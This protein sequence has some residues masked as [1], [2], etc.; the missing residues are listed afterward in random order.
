MLVAVPLAAFVLPD[1]IAGR[2]IITGD[3]LQQN[4]PLHVLVGSML[5]HGELP[6]WNQYIFSG[7][8]LMA[9]FNAGAFYPLM[10]LFVILPDRAAWIATEVILFS[11][12]AIGMYV[13]LRA[14]KLS[15]VACLLGAATFA[16]AGPVLSQ[17]N[18]VDMTEGYVAIPWMLLAVLHIVRDGRWRWSILLGIGFATVILAGAPEAMLDEAILVIAFAAMSAGLDP[19]R[20]WRVLSRGAAGTALALSLA[21]IQ[22]LP[23]LEAI[24]NSQR[25]SGVFA[26]A[27]SFPTPFSI[28]AVVPYLDGGYG[29]LGEAQFF[30]QYN[31]PEVGIYLGILPLIALLTLLHPRWPSRL[32]V[33]DRLTWYVVGVFGFVLALGSNTPLERFFNAVPLYG[34]QRLQSRNMII[35]ATAMSVLFA[36]WIDR[37]DAPRVG[38]RWSRYDR[39]VALVPGALVLGLAV[40]AITATGSLVHVFAGVGASTAVTKT[41]RIAT[42]VALAFCAGA[43]ALVWLRPRLKKVQWLSLAGVFVAVDLGLMGLTS[44]LTMVPP[45]DLVSGTTPV[46]QL[47]AAHLVPGGRFIDYDPQTYNSYPESP[48]GIPD[49]NIIPGLPSVSG[50]A[51]IVNG[52]Y[53]ATTH[54]HEQGNVD[55]GQLGNGTLSRLNLQEIVTLPEYFLLPLASV[56]A[57]ATGAPPLQVS[58]NIGSDPV[59]PRGFS[60]TY[61]QTSYPYVPGPRPPLRNGQ[62]SSWFFGESLEP[63]SATLLFAHPAVAGAALRFGV[64]DAN[65]AIRWTP[66]V[67][68]AAGAQSV[69]EPLPARQGVALTVQ[70]LGTVPSQSAVIKVGTQAYALSGALSTAVVPGPWRLAGTSQGFAVFTSTRPP[71]PISATTTSGHPVRVHVISTTTKSEEVRIDTPGPATVVRSV[72]WDQGWSGSVSVNGAAGRNVPVDSFDLVQRVSIPAGN[73]VV[74]FRYRP[75]HL[76]AGSALSIGAV[77][78]LLVLLV[79]WLVV[80]RRR[81]VASVTTTEPERQE[82]PVTV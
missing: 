60:S 55:I 23:G 7:T 50:Y 18:H 15:T 44:Q 51:S 25:G 56:P 78:L 73:D 26:A 29:H 75:P 19:Q 40:W 33:R 14:L 63:A 67:P 58:D 37:T 71:V 5:S 2:L 49:L 65:G 80:R 39:L 61:N 24:R 64:L 34:H 11:A 6:F 70:A 46:Q 31:L 21:A 62:T 38:D 53:E 76:L 79:G 30:G 52:N 57:S 36:G 69:T 74:T 41:V 3:N 1:L 48:Q 12:I 9:G 8:P 45:N 32:A 28:F 35:V 42:F 43:A 66:F 27:G 16:F 82:Q 68:V 4:Y 22:W 13:F 72:A 59:L 20:W 81:P 47:M 54:T 10:G 77:A 17:V